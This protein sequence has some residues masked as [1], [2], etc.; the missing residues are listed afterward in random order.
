MDDRLKAWNA[1]MLLG[2]LPDVRA[3]ADR[4]ILLAESKGLVLRVTQGL[5]SLSEQE[6]IYAKGRTEQGSV[7]TN[8]RPGYS[9]HNFGRAYDVAVV[10]GGKVVW[11][12]R[13]YAA[14]GVLGK[15]VGLVWGGDF[16]GMAGDLGHFEYHPGLTLAEA[17]K[18]AGIT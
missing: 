2:L 8:A 5:R 7:V 4:H 1:R 9:W 18:H 12:S 14:V 3:I 13:Q 6:A 10:I 16:K 17:R 15:S 11:E